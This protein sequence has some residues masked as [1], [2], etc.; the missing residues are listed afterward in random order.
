MKLKQRRHRLHL[1][2]QVQPVAQALPGAAGE[3]CDGGAIN[4]MPNA[5]LV[6]PI[7]IS[8]RNPKTTRRPSGLWAS[9]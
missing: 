9:P 7:E 2:L 8:G 6:E 4:G 3:A 5:K 1:Q